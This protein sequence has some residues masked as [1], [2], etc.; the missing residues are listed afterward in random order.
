MRP[1]L[2]TGRT[3]GCLSRCTPTRVGTHGPSDVSAGPT[4]C[5][6]TRASGSCESTKR[7][8]YAPCLFGLARLL[9]EKQIPRRCAA[10]IFIA[11][12]VS[13]PDESSLRV[14][15]CSFARSFAKSQ[16][17]NLDPGNQSIHGDNFNFSSVLQ[18]RQV[19]GRSCSVL[20]RSHRIR[21]RGE[22]RSSL[23]SR[24]RGRRFSVSLGGG[25][26]KRV[27]LGPGV[28]GCRGEFVVEGAPT[29]RRR[30]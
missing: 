4:T 2:T 9:T 13:V 6:G 30:R 19:R 3:A 5:S 28:C 18:V 26:R 15:R 1:G 10:E 22:A 24:C 7:L 20:R 14:P 8:I 23:R 25:G 17:P 27:F 11:P 16:R 21:H 29:E 12:L